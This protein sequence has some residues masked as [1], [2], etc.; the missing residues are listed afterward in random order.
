MILSDLN[1][2]MLRAMTIVSLPPNMYSVQQHHYPVIC[3]QSCS[4]EK[5]TGKWNGSNLL[6]AS[7]L[8]GGHGSLCFCLGTCQG[9][10]AMQQADSGHQ[11]ARWR[12]PVG[13]NRAHPQHRINPGQQSTI[14]MTAHA[15]HDWLVCHFSRNYD[16]V[17]VLAFENSLGAAWRID[18]S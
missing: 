6:S 10:G 9:F 1:I 15:Q 11:L 13:S 2:S 8:P 7:R 5:Y 4:Y 17:C 12:I 3:P 16:F 14:C 18:I